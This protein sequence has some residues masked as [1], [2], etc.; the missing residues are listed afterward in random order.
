MKMIST[1]I[2]LT[3]LAST[4]IAIAQQYR[5]SESFQSPSGNIHCYASDFD[6]SVRCD[7][8]SRTNQPPK[9]PADCPVDY[10]NAFEVQ[11]KG[12]A[13]LICYGDTVA[14][15]ANPVLPYGTKWSKF[16]IVC[17][18]ETTGVT[19]KN[20]FNNGFSISKAKQSVF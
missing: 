5:S 3:L 20:P 10:G 13:R 18:S 12:N 6:K 1:F 7:L 9:K 11:S 8:M 2:G 14:N 15:P 19:C 16:G 17:E 4:H